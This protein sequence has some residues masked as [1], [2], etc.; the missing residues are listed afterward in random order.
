M[1]VWVTGLP[2]PPHPRPQP[3]LSGSVHH[4][5]S[6]PPGVLRLC[7]MASSS[8]AAAAAVETASA[9]S[10]PEKKGRPAASRRKAGKIDYDAHIAAKKEQIKTL[11]KELKKTKA[12][13]RN[14]MR[15]KARLVRKASQLTLDDLHRIAALKKSGIWDP[16]LGLP[17]VPVAGADAAASDGAVM[18]GLLPPPTAADATSS[19]QTLSSA[20][21]PVASDAGPGTPVAVPVIAAASDGESDVEER[22]HVVDGVP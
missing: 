13:S 20:T 18:S 5:F 12:D 6:S 7:E 17:D 16:A 4:S 3:W 22:P 1:S 15:K 11:A 21:D 8:A 2:K 14:E 9:P 19:D 10:T